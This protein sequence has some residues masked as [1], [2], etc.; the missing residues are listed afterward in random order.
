[1]CKCFQK[2]P[3]ASRKA[4][5][6]QSTKAR[7][8]LTSSGN[9]S[10]GSALLQKSSKS[11]SWRLSQPRSGKLSVIFPDKIKQVGLNQ[12]DDHGSKSISHT[13]KH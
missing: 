5:V 3:N 9:H 2:G 4:P 7:A 8:N 6:A 13:G 12:A 10:R 1:M 11:V